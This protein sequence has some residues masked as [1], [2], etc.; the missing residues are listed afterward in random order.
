MFITL[1]K[2]HLALLSSAPACLFSPTIISLVQPQY[3]PIIKQC[4][5]LSL[6]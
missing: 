1:H 6:L 3:L 5:I 4:D 2:L